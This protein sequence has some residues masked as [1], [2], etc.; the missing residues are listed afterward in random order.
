MRKYL[1]RF[2]FFLFLLVFVFLVLPFF[3]ALWV[4]HI[5]GDIVCF[6]GVAEVTGSV[7]GSCN[8]TGAVEIIDGPPVNWGRGG[9]KCVAA[10]RAGGK[11]YAVFIRVVEADYS[12]GEP[13][14]SEAERNLC[15]CAKGE[16]A[17]YIF[18]VKPAVLIAYPGILVVDVEEGVGY[19]SIVYRFP[20]SLWPFNYSYFIF[21][22]G[23]Y[24]NIEGFETLRYMSGLKAA[25]GAKREIGGPLLEGCAYRVKVKLEPEKL[26][27][28]QPLYNATARAVRVG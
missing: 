19:L 8:Y 20:L 1:K 23:V 13:F 12:T 27:I 21:G 14:K 5:G 24:L 9:F 16:I 22:D 25:V 28:S 17:L 18:G 4:C 26:T 11:T 7:W 2:L 6:G 3:A 10:G 15:F